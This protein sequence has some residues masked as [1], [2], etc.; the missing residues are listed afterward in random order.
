MLQALNYILSG[1]GL[2][3]LSSK[4]KPVLEG[5]N[6]LQ[7]QNNSYIYSPSKAIWMDRNYREF[8]NEA[9]AKNVVAYRAINMVAHAAASVPIK[10][11]QFVSNKEV[12][13]IYRHP[14]LDLLL[15]PNPIQNGKELLESLYIYK[16]ISG[17]AYLLSVL[18]DKTKL[19][20]ELYALRPDRVTI[21]AG[22]NFLPA[23]YKYKVDDS[24]FYYPVNQITGK[25]K[26]LHLKN[27]HPT[28]DWY[29]LSSIE[30]A[31]YSIDQH[32]QSASWNQ[33]LLQN[34]ARPSGAFIV[35]NSEGN[36]ATLSQE[37]YSRL[38]ELIDE[39]VSSSLNAGRPL[40]LEGGLEWKELSLSPKEMD[41]IEG[42]H[43]AARDIALAFGVPPQLLGIPGDNTYSNLQEARASFWEQTVVPLAEN[44]VDHIG[45]WLKSYYEENLELMIDEDNI[46]ALTSKRDALWDRLEKSSFLT[47]NEKRMQ[48]G[49]G[50]VTGGDV[51]K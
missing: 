15:R 21:V 23:G 10:L 38:K 26:I 30:P 2:A 44:T 14:M 39:S 28:S 31:A 45:R 8:A 19:P 46:T 7:E 27:V 20:K 50:P 33:A 25:S 4:A 17:N 5:M 48:V 13:P 49:L 3:K 16:Q 11:L 51:I 24:E 12:K 18:P 34:C 32:N 41:Y 6:K 22:N 36:P 29:G 37:Q 47:I 40:I 42:K 1:I 35:K 9:Y 43:S